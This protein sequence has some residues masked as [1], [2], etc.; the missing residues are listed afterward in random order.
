MSKALIIIDIQN[1]YFVDGKMPLIDS[2]KAGESARLILD[3][4]RLEK[5]PVVFMQHIASKP[6]ATFFLPDTKGAEIHDN[7]KP[8]GAEKVIIKHYPNSFRDTPLLDYLKSLNVTDLVICGMMT[9][10]CIDAT[11]RASKD[12]GFDIT[13]ISDAC[14]TKDLEIGG[15][16]V[17]ADD[18]QASFLA[19]LNYFYATVLTAEQYLKK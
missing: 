7:V 13:L 6:S 5:S 10:M 9:H 17:K 15:H 12:Y 8:L 4:F 18:V 3:K 2:D 1:D 16:T 14:A 11:V 19:A